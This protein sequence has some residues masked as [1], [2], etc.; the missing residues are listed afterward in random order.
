[1]IVISNAI[2]DIQRLNIYCGFELTVAADLQ[3]AKA[4]IEST[5]IHRAYLIYMYV[6]HFKSFCC[7]I[8]L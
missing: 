7:P 5:H 4:E 6:N 2:I 3:L 1:M 8:Q